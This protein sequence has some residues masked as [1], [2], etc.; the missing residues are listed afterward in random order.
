[1]S[2]R[3]TCLPHRRSWTE[4]AD[5]SWRMTDSLASRAE[6]NAADVVVV[7]KCTDAA[8][9]GDL[10]RLLSRLG[11]E[12]L[13]AL[14]LHGPFRTTESP[15]RRPHL[16]RRVPA[17]R[18]R[19]RW[20]PMRRRVT[21]GAE[22]RSLKHSGRI[23]ATPVAHGT[24]LKL[25]LFST[26]KTAPQVMHRRTALRV[27]ARSPLGAAANA[28][29]DLAEVGVG[30]KNER[31]FPRWT[32]QRFVTCSTWSELPPWLESGRRRRISRP[33]SAPRP[34]PTPMTNMI[35]RDRPS[36]TSGPRL[37]LFLLEPNHT[38]AM[39]SARWPDCQQA[40]IRSVNGAI[41]RS[42]PNVWRPFLRRGHVST[43]PAVPRRASK[44][45]RTYPPHRPR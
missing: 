38:W 32:K 28:R 12:D 17:P 3:S 31:E 14:R 9:T 43:A 41:L 36:P 18:F 20:R 1:M 37:L 8:R 42:R 2:P 6:R 19:S 15:R 35:P 11:S 22:S 13:C 25:L 21:L 26:A 45:V 34:S 24:T 4:P 23:D 7:G 29:R 5:C 39:S 44:G 10:R 27:D 40:S 16:R 30:S 33:S